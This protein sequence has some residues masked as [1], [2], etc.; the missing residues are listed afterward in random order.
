[1]DLED[2]FGLEGFIKQ[3]STDLNEEYFQKPS[4]VH[5]EKDGIDFVVLEFPED[6]SF[7]FKALEIKLGLMVWE[8]KLGFEV[9][10]MKGIVN[11][12]ESESM[13]SLQ[14]V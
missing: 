2:F 13:W 3:N 4:H 10:R 9:M 14:G 6:K 1:M 7:D 8:K 11:I 5:P 12:K